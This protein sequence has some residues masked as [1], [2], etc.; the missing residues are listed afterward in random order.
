MGLPSYH[1]WYPKKSEERAIDG[2]FYGFTKTCSLLNFLDVAKYNANHAHGA[3]FLDIDLL[4]PNPP[5]YQQ[6]L[7]LDP[8]SKK[9]DFRW[10]LLTIDL[11]DHAH[12]GTAPMQ[13]SVDPPLI[14]LPLES[15]L[16]FYD[17]YHLPLLVSTSSDEVFAQSLPPNFRRSIYI[18]A[19][20]VHDPVSVAEVLEAFRSSQVPNAIAQADLWIFK[21]NTHPHTDLEEQRTMFNQVR[22]APVDIYPMPNPVECRAVTSLQKPEFPEYVGQMVRSPFCYDFKHTHFGNYD[23]MY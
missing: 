6:V 12:F 3:H 9:Y 10:P 19:I 2:K 4:H 5:I 15:N 16:S 1:F 23:K 20:I 8:A 14:G 21:C 13:V 18:L 17:S 11:G 22:F 7:S